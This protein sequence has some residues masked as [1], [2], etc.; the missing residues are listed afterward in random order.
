MISAQALAVIDRARAA[1]SSH[2]PRQ[3]LAI[4]DEGIRL[5]PHD[6]ALY[7]ERARTEVA[8]CSPARPLDA[9]V[10]AEAAINLR[11]E[12]CTMGYY[13]KAQALLKLKRADDA[14]EC[15]LLGLQFDPNNAALLGELAQQRD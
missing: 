7:L 4:L 5:S 8:H 9:L 13:W 14:H 12:R 6:A 3:A 11:P 1:R 15:A 10:S 2:L